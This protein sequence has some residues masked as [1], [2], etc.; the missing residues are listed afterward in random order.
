MKMDDIYQC[1]FCK[2]NFDT[3]DKLAKDVDKCVVEFDKKY[4]K[5]N[6]TLIKMH[7]NIKTTL[8]QHFKD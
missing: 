5:G 7:Q 2:N 8:E 6:G 3:T 4:F 1:P